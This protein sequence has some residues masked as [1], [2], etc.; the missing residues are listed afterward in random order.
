MSDDIVL[1]VDTLEPDEEEIEKEVCKDEYT[2]EQ[3]IPMRKPATLVQYWINT[4]NQPYKALLDENELSDTG[5]SL[6]EKDVTFLLHS[7]ISN[8]INE[9]KKQE[10]KSESSSSS[11]NT[12][13]YILSN[14]NITNKADTIAIIESAKYNKNINSLTNICIKDIKLTSDNMIQCIENARLNCV[15]H[16]DNSNVN[17][18]V[19]D[20][21]LCS[22]SKDYISKTSDQPINIV[23][24]DNM[25]Q[26]NMYSQSEQTNKLNVLSFSEK[27]LDIQSRNDNIQQFN[28]TLERLTGNGENNTSSQE[29][30]KILE[31]DISYKEGVSEN[32]AQEMI[33]NDTSLTA[34]YRK[35]LYTGR[36][37]PIDLMQTEKHSIKRLSGTMQNLHPALDSD[38]T[39]KKKTSLVHK[40]KSKN[41]SSFSKRHF[42]SKKRKKKRRKRSSISDKIIIDTNNESSNNNSQNSSIIDSSFKTILLDD[43]NSNKRNDILLLERNNANTFLK[44]DTCKDL[45]SLNINPVVLL[46]RIAPSFIQH[47]LKSAKN[48]HIMQKSNVCNSRHLNESKLYKLYGSNIENV[49]TIDSDESTLLVCQCKTVSKDSDCSFNLRLSTEDDFSVSNTEEKDDKSSNSK[50]IDVS[51]N[52]EPYTTILEELSPHLSVNKSINVKSQ[53]IDA[54]EG[55]LPSSAMELQIFNKDDTIRQKHVL[56]KS[57]TL[58]SNSYGTNKIDNVKSREIKIVLERLPASVNKNSTNTTIK[59]EIMNKNNIQQKEILNKFKTHFSNPYEMNRT[60]NVKLRELKITLE[61]LSSN[62]C[63]NNTNIFVDKNIISNNTDLHNNKRECRI[64]KISENVKTSIRTADKVDNNYLFRSRIKTKKYNDSRISDT[65]DIV[66]YQVPD[67]IESEFSIQY[68]NDSKMNQSNHSKY[69]VLT[70]TSSD[71]DDFVQ[72]IEHPKKRSKCSINDKLLDETNIIAKN[73][74]DEAKLVATNKDKYNCS[75][76]LRTVI[77]SSK[78]P[79][80]IRKTFESIKEKKES[81]EIEIK[82]SDNTITSLKMCENEKL[83]FFPNEN[84]NDSLA[85]NLER[86]KRTSFLNC[87]KNISNSNEKRLTTVEMERNGIDYKDDSCGIFFQ[88]KTFYSDSSDFEENNSHTASIR[89][90]LKNSSVHHKLQ[91]HNHA[92]L[93]EIFNDSK[94]RKHSNSLNSSFEKH[95]ATNQIDSVEIEL[96]S[97]NKETK[98]SKRLDN[99]EFNKI[100]SRIINTKKDTSACFINDISIRDTTTQKNMYSSISLV[101]NNFSN[102]SENEQISDKSKNMSA[103]QGDVKSTKLLVFQT[104]TYYDSDSNDS[105]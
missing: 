52:K 39:I 12:A 78:K 3:R 19:S 75:R 85:K 91:Y 17:T 28:E 74:S 100:N 81:S 50:N 62:I 83:M 34:F 4:G 45:S 51:Q 5:E 11:V 84:D 10:Y 69:S 20:I 57:K 54:T 29:R 53:E 33:R 31:E 88:T 44:N 104:K 43:I 48:N 9:G 103:I 97:N 71:E 82:S 64:R 87:N 7:S 102:L 18:N 37:S 59:T 42:G 73:L 89:K 86:K 66:E 36:N 77:F 15:T 25:I 35:K 67:K 40:D 27:S 90:T 32:I 21:E 98:I 41:L 22:M 93:E 79:K 105:L 61:R 1:N 14:T 76:N 95:E 23:T 13:A 55:R 58:S 26:P 70:F 46:E 101:K 8:T 6:S 24:S 16:N 68:K 96:G 56:N 30:N 80:T 72:L 2:C 63:I 92:N 94:S 65:S 99:E 38:C 60:D 49:E 47:K